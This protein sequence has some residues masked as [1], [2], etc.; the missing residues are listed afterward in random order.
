[1]KGALQAVRVEPTLPENHHFV[2]ERMFQ[3]RLFLIAT[4]PLHG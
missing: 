2:K 1:M 3:K 4:A